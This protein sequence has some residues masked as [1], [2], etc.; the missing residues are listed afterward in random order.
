MRWPRRRESRCCSLTQRLNTVYDARFRRAPAVHTLPA[1]PR[2]R[3]RRP[4]DRLPPPRSLVERQH[5]LHTHSH[6][7][8][9]PPHSSPHLPP[10]TL[11]PLLS[12]SPLQRQPH[13][14]HP[15]PSPVLPFSSL[16][17]LHATA[18]RRPPSFFLSFLLLLSSLSFLFFFSFLL[19]LLL[20]SFSFL[21]FP[22]LSSFFPFLSLLLTNPRQ[23]APTA[24]RAPPTPAGSSA[25]NG[26]GR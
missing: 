6:T 14:P 1:P 8:S 23:A 20:S 26:A 19:F 21:F 5:P 12:L 13:L 10:L 9:P 15:L 11:S 3:P 2:A 16:Y 18:S 7:L 25:P 4:G 17:L 24:R 22:S